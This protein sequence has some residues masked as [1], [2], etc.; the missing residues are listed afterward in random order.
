[1]EGRSLLCEWSLGF[2]LRHPYL[3]P[4]MRKLP[5]QLELQMLTDL[6]NTTSTLPYI[7]IANSISAHQQV[8]PMVGIT[9][10]PKTRPADQLLTQWDTRGS[11]QGQATAPRSPNLALQ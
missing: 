10:G 2:A 5:S 7:H 6:R 11:I 1:L 8:A 4:G 9:N 3:A